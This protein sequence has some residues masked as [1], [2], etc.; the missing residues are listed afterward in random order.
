VPAEIRSLADDV[1]AITGAT[2]GIGAATARQL[3]EAGARVV[4]GARHGDRLEAVARELG[5]DRAVAVVSDTRRPGDNQ[6]LVDAA[7]AHF[8][9]LTGL[10]ANAGIGAYGSILDHDDETVTRMIETNYSG[11]VWA[12]RAAVPALLEQ[13][14]GDIVIVASVAGLRGGA[15]EAI[16]AGTKFAQVGLAGSLDRELRPKGIRV[17]AICPAGVATEFAMGTGRTPDMPDLA[18]FLEADDVAFAVTTTLRQPRR[19]R[20]TLWSLWSNGQ[21]S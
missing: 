3:V 17:T 21:G 15:D 18:S 10:V 11:T 19:L 4:L 20:T 5:P 14:G 8:G 1:I 6:A 12:V 7:K 2:S 16:Y 13:G 9:K